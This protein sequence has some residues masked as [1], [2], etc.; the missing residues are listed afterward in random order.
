MNSLE[1][2]RGE[3]RNKPPFPTEAGLFGKPTVI[4]NVETLVNVLPI[5]IEG[6]EGLRRASAPSAR[7]APSSSASPATWSAPGSTRRRSASPCGELLDLAGGIGGSGRLQAVLLGG[8]AGA[9]VTPDQLDIPLTFEGTRA[10][11]ATLGSARGDAVRRH[12]RP[13]PDPAPHRPVLP[14]RVVR[15][16][17]P[18]PRRH[19]APGGAAPPPGHRPAAGLGGRG[20]GRCS[21][22]W[23]RRC[24]TPPSAASARPPRAPSSRRSP[25]SPRSLF[26]RGDELPGRARRQDPRPPRPAAGEPPPRPPPR[27]GDHHRRPER[28]R[29]RGRD[30]ARRRPP[31]RDR[32]ADPLLS[33]EPDAGQRLPHLRGGG[34]GLA[35]AGPR[36]LAQGRAGDGGPYR[37]RARAP[38]PADGA[39]AAGARRSTSRPRRRSRATWSGTTPIPSA[40][41]R[42][43]RPPRR[44]ARRRA[45]RPPSSAPRW[46]RGH[47]RPAGEGGQRPLRPRLLEVHRL[48]Q[49]R[50]GLRHGRAEHLRHRASP[51]AASTP[52]SPPSTTSRCPTRPASTAATA[53]ASAPPAR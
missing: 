34:R 19:R 13:A 12:R 15:P 28:R 17:R 23:G 30:A 48:L 4:N 22:S 3:P 2:R 43:R 24:A 26:R 44:R 42:R 31:A 8:A 47:R 10:A 35:H 49:V 27:G 29:A 7:P 14:R 5:V 52:A 38:E 21:R 40:S 37:F 39:G 33:G 16:V 51:A 53:S 20:G 32:H 11:G 45:A 41:A 9:F 36:L 50:R 18:L 46:P 6:G 25:D 1:G